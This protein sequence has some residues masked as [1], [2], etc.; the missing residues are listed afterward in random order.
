MDTYIEVVTDNQNYSAHIGDYESII[1]HI[2]HGTNKV[3]EFRGRWNRTIAFNP[4]RV[5]GYIVWDE[6]SV[7]TYKDYVAMCK[8]RGDDE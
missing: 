3:M 8:A 6:V 2:E 1:H 5:T 4:A 7:A